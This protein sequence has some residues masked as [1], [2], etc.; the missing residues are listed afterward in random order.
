MSAMI[1][2]DRG[3]D[4]QAPGEHL[5]GRIKVFEFRF[6]IDDAV[7]N[8]R[9]HLRILSVT[10]I[11]N[12]NQEAGPKCLRQIISYVLHSEDGELLP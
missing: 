3:L 11:A 10:V 7:E 5:S 4:G 6:T 9:S 8:R 12:L 2:E 1:V